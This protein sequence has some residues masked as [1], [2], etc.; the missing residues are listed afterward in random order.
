MND[1]IYALSTPVG[2]AIAVIRISGGDTLGALKEIFTGEIRHRYVSHGSIVSAEGQPIDD[3]MAVYFKAPKSYTGEDMAELYI[4]GGYAVSKRVLGRLGELNMRPAEG[5]EFTRRAFLAGKLDLARSEAVM[6]LVTASSE[7]GAA[8]ALEQLQGALS[9]RINAI[10]NELLDLLS[11]IDAAIDYPEELEEDVFSAL[12]EGI[13]RAKQETD[14][15]IAGGLSSRMVR[16]GARIA[17]LGRPNAGKSSL[18]NALLGE[19]RAIVTPEAGTTRDV[20]EGALLINGIAARLFDT[21]GLREADSAAESIGV[22][23]AREITQRAD[24]LLI[25]MDG[26]ES[27]TGEERRLLSSAGRRLAVICKNDIS[28]G[29][30]AAALAAELGVDCVF[31]SSVTGEGIEALI[32][33]IAELIA[34]E[35]ESALVTNSRHIAALRSCSNALSSALEANEPDCIATDLRAALIALGDITGKSVDASVIDR[36]FSRF[37]VGK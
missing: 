11:G 4:H 26:G 12:P 32:D 28:D 21:A 17:I 34:P 15:L 10:E 24:L 9:N 27:P 31:I 23:R 18:F 25:A 37:C 30:E 3:A 14:A 7:R 20:I 8:S 36:I 1:T 33:K 19:D 35:C 13:F 5:G 2:G 16:E 6:D 22:A 29:A